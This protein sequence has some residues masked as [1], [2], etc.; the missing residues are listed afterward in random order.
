MMTN[1]AISPLT[2]ARTLWKGFGFIEMKI[3]L[4]TLRIV[5]GNALSLKSTHIYGAGGFKWIREFSI[6]FSPHLIEVKFLKK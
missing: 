2:F 1:S 4:F 6:D 3:L 5:R